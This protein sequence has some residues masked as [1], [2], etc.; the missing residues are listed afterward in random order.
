MASYL[1]RRVLLILPTLLGITIV[2]F[3]AMALSPGGVR[4][5]IDA[6]EAAMDP[7]AR[8]AVRAFLEKKYGLDKP[9]PVQ[10]LIW[11]NKV[12]PIGK[13]DAGVGWPANFP[14]GFKIPD[15]GDSINARRPVLDLIEESLPIT[16]LLNLITLPL[17]IGISVWSGI[18]AARK[19]GG[20]VDVGGGTLLLALWSIPQIWAGVLLIGFLA[21]KQ[22]LHWFP[23]AGLHDI[24]A[25]EMNFLPSFAGGFSRG[26]LLD[27]AWHLALPIVCYTYAG[28]A[29]I[30]KLTRGAMLENIA[31]DFVRTARAKGVSERAVIY[32]HVLR[33]SLL[34]LITSCASILPALISGTIVIE[35]IFSIPGMGKL[36]VDAVFDKD[37]EMVL[38]ITLV[39]SLLGLISFLLADIA[40]AIADPRVT[41]V[42]DES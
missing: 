33:N 27:A 5:A 25:D 36:G 17:M 8:A 12:S 40:Y 24:R 14:V 15:L 23:A 32:R 19:R 34:P 3:G 31:A 6:Q 2:T 35:Y 18:L 41:F 21:N 9:L 7:R 37:P 4:G 42:G 13:K 39:A 22:L 10:Y 28:F 16:L 30:S 38:S 29:F 1:I 26:W 11:L 20:V